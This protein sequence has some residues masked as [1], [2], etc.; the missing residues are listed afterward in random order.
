MM[1]NNKVV[2]GSL[3]VEGI[4]RMMSS[5]GVVRNRPECPELPKYSS[6]SLVP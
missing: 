6:L 2:E 1:H 3:S 4:R 5:T